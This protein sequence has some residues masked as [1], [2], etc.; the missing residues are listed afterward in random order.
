ME[1]KIRIK[2]LDTIEEMLP[3]FVL[4][5]QLNPSITLPQYQ[6]YLNNMIAN[7]YSQVAAFDGDA[8]AGVSGYWI[9]TKIYCGKYLEIDNFIVD[10]SY[11]NA[12]IGK[13]LLDWM[14]TKAKEEECKVVLLDAFL[15]NVKAH[16]FYYREG[17]AVRGFH[18]VKKLESQNG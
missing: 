13:S 6:E 9:S 7:G 15:M 2:A 17:F 12:G 11:R 1:T 3:M 4:I 5:Q 10:E 8:L 14:E 16:R 18:F